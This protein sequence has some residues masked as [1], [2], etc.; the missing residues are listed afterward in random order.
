MAQ[1]I[2]PIVPAEQDHTLATAWKAI[3]T[4]L[5]Q[6][7]LGGGAMSKLHTLRVGDGDI[8]ELYP[9]TLA[10]LPWLRI[11][12]ITSPC[13]IGSESEWE[14]DFRFSVEIGIAG[15]RYADLLN[16]YGAFITALSQSTETPLGN[17]QEYYRAAGFRVIEIT[18]AAI[19]PA[20][21]R[22]MPG[23]A[24]PVPPFMLARGVVHGQVFFAN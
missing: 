14:I 10:E 1:S 6:A 4:L 3:G 9:P 23:V 8:D 7:K 20:I 22:P 11:A 17:V 15:T 19:G 5:Q 21:P 24:A 12:P 2:P 13:K 16:L 18:E